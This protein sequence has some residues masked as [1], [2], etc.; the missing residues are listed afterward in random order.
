MKMEFETVRKLMK[1]DDGWG[2]VVHP[3]FNVNW[4]PD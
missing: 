1:L 2:F 3:G 4:G